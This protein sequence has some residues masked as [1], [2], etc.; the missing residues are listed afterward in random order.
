[1]ELKRLHLEQLIVR[2][3]R[4]RYA[5]PLLLL[6][7]AW[8]GAWCW[9][10]TLELCFGRR[11]DPATNSTP[12]LVIA[13]GR[14]QIFTMEEQNNLAQAYHAELVVIPEAAHDLMLDPDWHR[15]VEAI[16]RFVVRSVHEFSRTERPA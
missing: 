11:P 15:A 10:A 13:A 16:E 12:L 1:M 9:K 6:H 7:G 8:H 14:D 4:R 2:P 5:V 3:Q